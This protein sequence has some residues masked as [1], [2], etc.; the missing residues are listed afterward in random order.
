MSTI[1][2]EPSVLD[3]R[4]TLPVLPLRDV[5]VFPHMIVPLL[6]GRPAS[7]AALQEAQAGD[8]T[9][10]VTTQRSA[11]VSEPGLEDLHRM[12]VVCRVLQ[13]VR[14]PE[15]T[16]K[17][18]IEGLVRARLSRFLRSES[19]AHVKIQLLADVEV[20]SPEIEALQRS[21]ATQFSEYVRL[22]KRIPDEVLVS[23]VGIEEPARLCDTI[24]AHVIAKSSVK[25]RVLEC[26]DLASRFR[27]LGRVL[28]EELEILQIERKIEGEIKTSVQRNQKEF[29]LNEQ[30][31]AIR[32]ELGLQDGAA[33]DLED[34]ADAVERAR[35]SPEARQVAERELERLVRMPVLSP[36]ATVARTYVETLCELPW[37]RT[38]RDRLDLARVRRKLDDDHYGLER[39]K[40]R[41]LEFLAVVKLTGSF[42]GPIL[43]LV[44]P[45]GV[46]KTSLGRSI[47]AAMGRKFVR[48][49]LGGVHD[50]AEI[51][52]HRRTYV[53]AMPG[54]IVQALRKCGSSNPVFLLDELDKLGE[55]FRGDPGAAL[56]EALDPEQNS[57]F[58]DHYVEVPVDLSKVLFVTTANVLHT[59]PPALCDR[60]EIIQLP[61]YLDHEKLAI[62][63]RFLL[64]KQMREH[65]LDDARLQVTDAALAAIIQRYTR[66]AGVRALEREIGKLCRKVARRV[67]EAAPKRRT[68]RRPASLRVDA[69][70]LVRWLSVP[71]YTEKQVPETEEVGV[72][73]GLAWTSTGGEI[74]PI[75]VNAMS[76]C[77]N[78]IMTGQLGDVMRESGRAALSYVRSIA[79]RLGVRKDFFDRVDI[80]VHVP[81]GAIP[82]DGPSA[83]IAM[84][85]AMASLVSGRPVDRRLAMTGEI[86]LRGKA[87]AIGGLNEKA[88][89][90]LRAGVTTMLVPHDNQKDL[91]E[92]PEHVRRA[93]DIV[94]VRDMEEV[95]QRALRPA[96]RARRRR[97]A[98]GAAR[99]TPGYAH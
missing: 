99:G 69:G 75:E 72:A 42:R 65:G 57:G 63:R 66:E 1:Q 91:E 30:M 92:L 14:L 70:D 22:N 77:G 8:R 87:L 74:L 47:A 23:V 64:P 81:E 27:L 43:C 17:V 61:G 38:T 20:T 58:M 16:Y 21:V 7:V 52:G 80:H 18:L 5:V 32:K 79:P 10:F 24:A 19:P 89:A 86:T 28:G 31:K 6:V 71:P 76:G 94:P 67:A 36:E 78:L 44:G 45:P 85:T 62:G 41:I 12:G 55:D 51:R 3:I 56:L 15:G 95:L 49:S 54:R 11:D 29:Y 25:Q 39:V 83:G 4:E 37:R 50:E 13:L 40:E 84:A 60:L 9:L 48:V 90:A 93:L 82:K 46:G 26:V 53:G 33:S 34:L 59:I 35:L 97:R 2:S 88:V 98:A 96:G 73:T 68:S